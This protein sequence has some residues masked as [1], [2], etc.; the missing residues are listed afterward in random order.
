MRILKYILSILLVIWGLLIAW[1]KLFSVGLHFPF[2]TILTVIAIIAG[3]TKHKKAS[4][5]FIISACLWIILSAET[6]GF[7][8]FFDEGNYGRMLFGVI[9]FLLSTGLLFSTKTEIK[10]IDTLT[11]KFL[12]VPLFMLIGI[13]SYIYKPTT[14]EVNCWYYLNNDKT[15][16]VRF[17]ETPERTFEVELSSD[18]LKKEV[19]EE[20]L[21]YEGRKGYY[22][23]ETKVRVV[24][25]FGKIISAKIMSFR[26]SEI[27]KKVNFSSPTKIPLE[28]VNGKLEILKPFILRLWN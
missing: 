16:N 24:T 11:K 25:S 20:A 2:L 19:K 8:I 18:E 17:A 12:L 28:K 5:I 7:V 27:D 14:E 1:T 4:L 3:I 23:P 22:C 10:L 13:G 6:I 21:Q 26:N 15:Y 9:P